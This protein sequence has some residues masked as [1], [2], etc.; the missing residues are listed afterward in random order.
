[1]ISALFAVP[2]PANLSTSPWQKTRQQ[3]EEENLML[4]LESASPS[5]SVAIGICV[6][7]PPPVSWSPWKSLWH[8][9]LTELCIAF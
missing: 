2:Y 9:P 1:M 7:F 4:S 6:S 5:L 8:L 3:E